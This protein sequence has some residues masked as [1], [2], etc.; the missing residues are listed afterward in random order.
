MGLIDHVDTEK[1]LLKALEEKGRKDTWLYENLLRPTEDEADLDSLLR[2]LKDRKV[3]NNYMG[4][5]HLITPDSE[6]RR[7][8]GKKRKNDSTVANPW[9]WYA[10][11]P[12]SFNYRTDLRTSFT[13]EDAKVFRALAAIITNERTPRIGSRV[14]GPMTE[15][16]GRYITRVNKALQTF[17]QAMKED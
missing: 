11:L 2:D 8:N 14:A 13:H 1:R 15:E 10:W 16:E 12:E 17:Q 4:Y 5:N 9:A 6:D 7:L 3:I